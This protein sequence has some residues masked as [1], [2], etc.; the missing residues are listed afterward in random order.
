MSAPHTDRTL[1]S[2]DVLDAVEVSE[3]RF[4][5]T[6]PR[7]CYQTFGDPAGRPLLLV[8]GL[9]GPMTWWPEEMCRYLASEGFLVVRYDNRDTGRSDR[10]DH[11]RLGRTH[12]VRAFF[13]APVTAAYSL[14]DMASDGIGVLDTL[15]IRAAHVA[16]VSMGGMIA[17]TMTI[18]HPERVLSL[19]SIMSSTGSRR[20]GWQDPKLMPRLLT[21]ADRSRQGYI[22][23]SAKFWRLTGSPGFLDDPEV[24]RTR[25]GET[26][27]RGISFGG[28]LR[29]MMAILTAPDRTK[30][31]GD[32][33][34]PV[35]I[36]HGTADRM[37]HS[38][39]GR[40]CAKA[41]RGGELMLVPGMGHDLPRALIPTFVE[42]ISRSASRAQEGSR[43][44]A[45]PRRGP[46]GSPATA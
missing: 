23:S 29:Q 15:G 22:E 5:D 12:L 18:E 13:K 45:P 6:D 19:T 24:Q 37:V 11:H 31:L 32:V 33:R 14:A 3:E 25:A 40:A 8:M 20:A 21:R 2:R 7:I 41:I 30:R 28:V 9:S 36:V 27:D 10:I 44:V 26:W 16:G 38:S 34:V 17:Q 43:A 1:P 35:T 4:T 42:A 39:G 46:G